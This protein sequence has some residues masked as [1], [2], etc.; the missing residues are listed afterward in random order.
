MLG[1]VLRICK[2]NCI[3][4]HTILRHPGIIP[5]LWK[6]IT[7][8][9]E[10]VNGSPKIKTAVNS[11]AET[12]MAI[13]WP[14]SSVSLCY[15]IMKCIMSLVPCVWK[16]IDI[17]MIGREKEERIYQ[18]SAAGLSCSSWTL[19]AARSPVVTSKSGWTWEFQRVPTF[20]F[21]NNQIPQGCTLKM[22]QSPFGVLWRMV[23]PADAHGIC[24]L[25]TLLR[26]RSSQD[27]GPW[28]TL[29]SMRLDGPSPHPLC[30]VF[31]QHFSASSVILT[32]NPQHSCW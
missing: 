22:H 15:E 13:C 27:C 12:W 1:I 6:R 24:L 9:S 32:G 18:Q 25:V 17:P 3:P 8:S 16:L 19:T 14:Q 28:T 20:N 10:R 31:V 5:T 26:G 7:R 23:P 30:L 4:F 11:S 2:D 29:L 21:Y